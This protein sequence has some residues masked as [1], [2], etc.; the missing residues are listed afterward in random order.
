MLTIACQ[1]WP[2][3]S[4]SCSLLEKIAGI[5]GF[6]LKPGGFVL[7]VCQVT[8]RSRQMWESQV[9]LSITL[10]FFLTK[11]RDPRVFSALW[12]NLP[13]SAESH[14]LIIVTGCNTTGSIT[15]AETLICRERRDCSQLVYCA[16]SKC[17]ST[18]VHVK[19]IG[20]LYCSSQGHY[21]MD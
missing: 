5:S 9:L 20:P 17:A 8:L 4:C 6:H 2:G 21:R 10:I 13:R 18:N 19:V 16:V 15:G 3:L 12:R 14:V 1:L 11:Q 7:G